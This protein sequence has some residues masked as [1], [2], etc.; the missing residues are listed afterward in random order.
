MACHPERSACIFFAY[1]ETY[2]AESRDPE[3][4]CSNH[5]E[6]GSSHH[7]S[8]LKFPDA[9]W[10]PES[11]RGL[12]TAPSLSRFAAALRDRLAQDDRESTVSPFTIIHVLCGQISN[13]IFG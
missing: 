1:K 13:Y 3:D 12:S 10:L 9:A 11:L 2:G 6:S 4:V 5:A 8:S 7:T